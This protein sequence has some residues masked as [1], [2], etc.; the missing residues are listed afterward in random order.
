MHVQSLKKN[1][2]YVNK[3]TKKGDNNMEFFGNHNII[4]SLNENG[5]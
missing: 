2:L 3:T 1:L 5:K 4:K